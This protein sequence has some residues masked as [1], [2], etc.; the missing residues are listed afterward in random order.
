MP[1]R[2][3]GISEIVDSNPNLA[4]PVRA[5]LTDLDGAVV[6]LE[7][8]VLFSQTIAS[9]TAGETLSER[10][11][12]FL[13][14]DLKWYQIDTDDATPL[15][16]QVRGIVTQSGGI[17]SGNTGTVKILGEV[18]G[19]SGLTPLGMVYASTVAGG[20]TQTKPTVAA[21]AGQKA[22]V[23][24]GVALS[25]T[26][27][28]LLR[29]S[30]SYIMREVL[31]DDGTLTIV[32]H[33]DAA[34]RQRRLEAV[35]NSSSA[36]SS[37][38]TNGSATQDED[39]SL[40]A[41]TVATYGADQC[42]GGTASASGILGGYPASSAFD[43]NNATTWINNNSLPC[44]LEYDFGTDK[45]IRKY[46]IRA[47]DSSGNVQSPTAW[48][49]E[50][51]NGSS[52]VAADTV[53]GE[54]GWSNSEQRIFTVDSAYSAER[55]RIYVT[56]VGSG[57]YCSIAEMEMMEA[58]TYADGN[59][60]L[61]QSIQVTGDQSV[62][63]IKLWLKKVGSPTGNLTVTIESDSSGAPSGSPI[64]NGTAGTVAASTLSTSYG[65]ITFTFSTPPTLT[66]STTYWIVLD[67]SDSISETNY[68]QWGADGSAP[69]YANGEMKSYAS[70]SWSAES[71]DACFDVV[72]IGEDY[73][74]R[75]V[76]GRW[77]GGT[78]DIATRMDNGSGLYGDTQTTFKNTSG[79][80]LD[81]TC[82]VVL[83]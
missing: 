8:G 50:Y 49:L 9:Q 35:V 34:T 18:Q 51:Y 75:A 79:G 26:T 25:S 22:L 47:R 68:V 39:V 64:S 4:A 30:A 27:V 38:E 63:T 17:L 53:S 74:E 2:Y 65:W 21:A 76:I 6:A 78:R 3:A 72:G 12:V 44:W 20:Y 10:D 23:P 77:G 13:A 42:S 16:G 62:G 67:T 41:S 11:A 61:A 71:K 57:T 55:W 32:H 70:S 59:E 5:A 15:M 83:E 19:F 31:A 80:D 33:A 69:G 52:W 58:A 40:E 82:M 1:N 54:T 60:K 73:V 66:G 37:L 43:N 56:A 45:T 46:T 14:D 29:Y 48:T 28:L 24:L 36:G 81:V 7:D